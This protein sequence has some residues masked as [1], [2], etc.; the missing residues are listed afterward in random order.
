MRSR[1]CGSGS[2]TGPAVATTC[3]RWAAPRA[4]SA[5]SL[6]AHGDRVAMH[7]PLPRARGIELLLD[8]FPQ[9]GIGAVA[10]AGQLGKDR[11]ELA[12]SLC[13]F[14]AYEAALD[15]LPL[16][17]MWHRHRDVHLRFRG[18]IASRPPPSPQTPG[19]GARDNRFWGGTVAARTP[20]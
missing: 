10:V 16:G 11:A 5:R 9:I 17:A 15:Y 7:D 18:G 20:P 2:L 14:L 3:L 8:P 6:A 4:R 13:A 12:N 1:P 19:G